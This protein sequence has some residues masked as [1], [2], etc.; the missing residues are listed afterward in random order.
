MFIDSYC[1]WGHYLLQV[2]RECTPTEEE[3]HR[4]MHHPTRCIHLG[5]KFAKRQKFRRNCVKLYIG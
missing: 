3:Q 5:S 2:Q 1:V 4:V